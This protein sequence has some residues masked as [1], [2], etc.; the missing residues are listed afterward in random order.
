MIEVGLDY[1]LPHLSQDADKLRNSEVP[2]GYLLHLSRV[3]DKQLVETEALLSAEAPD[4]RTAYVHLDTRPETTS[5]S[6]CTTRRSQQ[7]DPIAGRSGPAVRGPDC[8]P[9]LQSGKRLPAR[10]QGPSFVR[11]RVRLW[12]KVTPGIYDES[13]K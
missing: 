9:S 2:A 10:T 4:V 13:T 5:G 6:T 12:S 3:T 11:G 1:G 7:A 8:T